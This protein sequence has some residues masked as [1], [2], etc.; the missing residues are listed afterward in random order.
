MWERFAERT[1]ENIT[2]WAWA[3]AG[4]AVLLSWQ[5]ARKGLRSLAVAGVREGMVVSNRLNELKG[6]WRQAWHD[7]VAEARN[8][9]QVTEDV[10]TAATNIERTAD[11]VKEFIADD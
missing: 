4:A 7:L 3:V 5:P 1:L 11:E 8:V 6:N 2:P 9:A 10:K